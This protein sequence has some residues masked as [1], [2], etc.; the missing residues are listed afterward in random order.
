MLEFGPIILRALEKED[1]KTLHKWNNDY[2]VTLYSRGKPFEFKN[3][4]VMEEE[5]EKNLKDKKKTFL[6]IEVK[7][8][9]RL[10]GTANYEEDRWGGILS[11]DLGTMLGEK[12]C[13]NKG[14]GK[15]VTLGLCEL[16]FFWKNFDRLSAWSIE[17]NKRA[18]RV[19]EQ[20]GFVREGIIRKCSFTSGKYWDWYAF[21]YL[22]GEYLS[23]R[24]KIL[25]K[26]LKNYYSGYLKSIPEEMRSYT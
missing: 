17:Y 20:I 5:I 14:Y 1:V 2:I 11:S 16:L 18:H 8:E 4:L 22:K 19:L 12:D 23:K 26:I 9:N 13:W 25:Q 10:I 7:K 6:A 3:M 24:E 21:G 15:L